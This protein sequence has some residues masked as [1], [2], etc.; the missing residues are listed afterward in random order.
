LTTEDRTLGGLSS[1]VLKGSFAA[2]PPGKEDAMSEREL[3]L[4]IRETIEAAQA[5]PIFP[6]NRRDLKELYRYIRKVILENNLCDR[7]AA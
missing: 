2:N 6:K 1:V 3:R 4:E 7:Q 5:S